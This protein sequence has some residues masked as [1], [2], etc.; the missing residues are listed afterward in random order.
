MLNV[1]ECLLNVRDEETVGLELA[2]YWC[3]WKKPGK[4]VQDGGSD[5]VGR[6]LCLFFNIS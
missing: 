3:V 1:V 5:K 4:M 2:S 6:G